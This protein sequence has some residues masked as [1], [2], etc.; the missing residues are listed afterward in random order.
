MQ[1]FLKPISEQN[2]R[3]GRSFICAATLL[4]ESDPRQRETALRLVD[5]THKAVRAVDV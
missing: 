3:R 1:I 5:Q 2:H 4:F